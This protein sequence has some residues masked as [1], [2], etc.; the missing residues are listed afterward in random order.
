MDRRLAL[1]A[2]LIVHL[3]AAIFHG[4]SHTIVPVRLPTTLNMIVLLTVFIVPVVGVILARQDHWLGLPLFTVSMI[5][6]LLVGGV[7]HFIIENPDHVNQ[8]P[9]SQAGQL[10]EQSALAVLVTP[11]IGAI[12]GAISWQARQT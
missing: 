10:F 4:Y 6:A 9:A 8:V 5:G 12:Y 3:G 7:L 2:L 11:L 1:P